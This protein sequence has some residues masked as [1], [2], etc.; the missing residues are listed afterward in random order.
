MHCMVTTKAVRQTLTIP[1]RVHQLADEYAENEVRAGYRKTPNRSGLYSYGA[2]LVMTTA[3]REA[4]GELAIGAVAK[5]GTNAALVVTAENT[6]QLG[7]VRWAGR[8]VA[9]DESGAVEFVGEPW[10]FADGPI[11]LQGPAGPQAW[12]IELRTHEPTGAV[13][14]MVTSG[15]GVSL[16][17]H[18]P[19]IWL[20]QGTHA[21]ERRAN[22]EPL[23][24]WEWLHRTELAETDGERIDAPE[25]FDR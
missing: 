7:A 15:Q 2:M 10:S 3:Q 23:Q 20:A 1:S 13:G 5:F 24:C 16:S 17:K 8:W 12:S 11:E 9:R 14:F 21:I 6:V 25:G 4:V 22:H 19:Y 18:R